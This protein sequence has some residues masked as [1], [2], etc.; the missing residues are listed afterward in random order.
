MFRFLILKFP[1]LLCDVSGSSVIIWPCLFHVTGRESTRMSPTRYFFCSNEH[2]YY[3]VTVVLLQ[4]IQL[5]RDT[6]EFKE[7]ARL[8]ERTMDHPIKSIQ[9][10]QNLDLWEFFCRYG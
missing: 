6:H 8:Y 10:I 5:G 1:L 3:T 9:R 4:L 7:V 2:R